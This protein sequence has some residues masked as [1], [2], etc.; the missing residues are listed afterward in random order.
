MTLL[1]AGLLLWTALHLYPSLAPEARTRLVSRLGLGPYKG[2]FALVI[3]AALVLIVFGWRAVQP[4][5]IY[6]PPAWGRYAAFLLVL[7]T[8]ILFVA[9]KRRTNIKRVLRHPQLTGLVLWSIG[10]LLANGD[11][12]SLLL[13]VWLAVWAGMEMLTINRRAGPWVKPDP[14]PASNDAIVLVG[15]IVLFVVFFFAHPYLSGTRLI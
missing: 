12:R 14:V 7:P 9:A 11:H 5:Q 8:F 2:M 15:G 1:I 4:A 13:F 10:H 6:T 3:V